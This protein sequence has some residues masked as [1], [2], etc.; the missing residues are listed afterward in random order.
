MKTKKVKA[1]L[2][3]TEKMVRAV[4]DDRCMTCGRHSYDHCPKSTEALCS[5]EFHGGS[6]KPTAKVIVLPV[7]RIER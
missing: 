5:R 1:E 6:R 3:I 7:I 4:M 2:R